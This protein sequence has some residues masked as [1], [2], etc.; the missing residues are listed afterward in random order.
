MAAVWMR[1][2]LGLQRRAL[3]SLALILAV[4]IGGGGALMAFAG[5]RRTDSAVRRFMAYYNPPQGSVDPLDAADDEP[6]LLA[7]IGQ[8]PQ[9][10]ASQIG[11]RFL[12]GTST[13][14]NALA[15]GGRSWMSRPLI[16]AGRM[17][18]LDRADEAMINDQAASDLHLHV[19]ST[20]DAQ[21]LAP[22]DVL[23]A[24]RGAPAQPSGEVVRLHVVGII[25]LPSDL[26]LA[27]APAGVNFTAND[28]LFLTGAFIAAHGATMG[29]LGLGMS[30]R[31]RSPGD[32]AAF[33]QEVDQMSGG[34]LGAHPGSDDLAAARQ[35][36]HATSI[37]ALALLLF[38]LLAAVLT[39]ALLGQA[40]SRQAFVDGADYPVLQA[41]GVTRGQVAATA[42]LQSGLTAVLGAVLAAGLAFAA[43]S[44]MPIGL[45]RQAEVAPGLSFDAMVLGLGALIIVVAIIA[46]ASLAAWRTSGAAAVARRRAGSETPA[47]AERIGLTRFSPSFSIGV[48]MAL[49]PGRGA[50][51][52]PVRTMIFGVVVAIAAVGATVTFGV[53][54][55]RL[56]RQPHLQGWN[57]DYAIGNP[58]ADDT[59]AQSI[60]LLEADPD[61]TGITA[62]AGAGGGT[63]AVIP[64]HPEMPV[65]GYQAV[66]GS[67][68]PPF[69]A[70][71]AP[72]APNEIAL[73]PKTMAA[74]HRSVG[75][76]L[77]VGFYPDGG[78]RDML[79]T[80]EVVLTPAA[81]NDSMA[82]GQ[83]GLVNLSALDGLPPDEATPVNVFFVRLRP[84]SG[85]AA[86]RRLKS[87][88]PQVVLP[89]VAPP[90]LENL[91]RVDGLP[92]ALALLF[93]G[94]ALLTV[95]HTLV[96]GV[97]R[98]RRELAVLRTVGLVGGQVRGAIAWQATTVALAGLV[99][100]L[101]LGI[102]AGRWAWSLVDSGL[103]L[104]FQAVSPVILLALIAAATVLA[105]NAAAAVPAALAVR[106]RPA[107]A[108]RAE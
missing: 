6:A 26:S 28:N 4:G 27:P 48:R 5:A 58:H 18:N 88:F 45:A 50:S 55:D 97:R 12:L 11:A 44:A 63:A 71:R 73:A 74:M 92:A 34:R 60:P 107:E 7:Q 19:G 46:W 10:A 70:G 103:G 85:A 21:G 3:A 35:A 16:V 100:G 59:A 57:W 9:V 54:L 13:N 43:S 14:M 29:R 47:L 89:P 96:S 62:L 81:L 108:L 49:D 33:T 99:V 40:L 78:S 104:P 68:M 56:A 77:T 36:E 51:A 80:G 1:A 95:G 76:R 90:D 83:G 87:Q 20:I 25:R 102:V 41:M 2:R 94:V 72:Q 32:L 24:L 106:T 52:V 67:V 31:L 30:Y 98:R 75:Q 53:N 86:V 105:A 65:F 93:A 84:G 66:T 69:I 64:G 91:L 101:P 38:G 37:E 8:L 42:A 82:L 61:V 79:I 23:Q 17:A 22:S 15:F 39:A